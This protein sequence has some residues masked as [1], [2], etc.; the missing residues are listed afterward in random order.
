MSKPYYPPETSVID[1]LPDGIRLAQTLRGAAREIYR[2]QWSPEGERLAA[3]GADGVIYIWDTASGQVIQRLQQ[4]TDRVYS[5]TWSPDGKQLA[6]ISRDRSIYIWDAISGKALSTYKAEDKSAYCIAWSPDGRWL[7]WSSSGTGVQVLEVAKGEIAHVLEGQAQSIYGLAWSP[8]SQRIAAGGLDKTI[9]VWT[10]EAVQPIQTLEG[11]LDT[12]IS[13]GWSPDG[14]QLVSSAADKTIHIWDAERGQ[15]SV[16]IEGHTSYI[17]AAQFSA[18]GQLLASKSGDGTVR[19]WRCDT[20]DSVATLSEPRSPSGP[21]LAA[22]HFHPQNHKL[23]SLGENDTVVRLWELDLPKLMQS[24]SIM[25]TTHYTNAKVVLVGDTGVGKSGLSLVLIGQPFQE[26]E[27]THNR[28]VYV[29]E[30]QEFQTPDG[31]QE[32]RETLLWD[33]AGQPGYRLI[34]QLHLSD[35]AVALVVYDSRNEIDPFAGVFHWV[36]ALRQ[37]HQ[38]RSAQSLKIFL[39]AARIDRGQVG[40]SRKRIAQLI[41]SLE[42][43]G[44][45][46]TS[47]KEAWGIPELRSAVQSAIDWAHLPRV[48]STDFFTRIKSFIVDTK[49][50]GLVLESHDS[51]Y[52]SFLRANQ[53]TPGDELRKQFD[54]CI[55]L[56]ASRGL[57]ERF[58]FGDL[59]LLQPEILDAYASAMVNA[60]RTEPDGLGY[61]REEDALAGQ[62]AMP[63]SE[64]IAKAG[65]EKLLLIATVQKLLRH[66]IALRVEADDSSFLVFPSQL[67]RENPDLPAPNGK[68][69]KIRFEGAILN[70]YATL[71]VRLA[72]S[73]LF[74][75]RDMWKNA[76]AYSAIA[77]GAVC[78]LLLQEITES[79]AELILFYD[80]N[81]SEY[82]RYQFEHYIHSHLRRRALPDSISHSYFVI[83]SDCQYVVPDQVVEMRKERL[84]EWLDCPVCGNRISLVGPKDDTVPAKPAWIS[85][86]NRVA[87][88]QRDKATAVSTLKGKIAIGSYDVFLCHNNKD[89]ALVKR[90]GAKLREHGI[91]PWLDEWE[92]RPGIPWQKIL[93]HQ[94]QNVKAAAVFVGENGVGP[95]QD[96]EQA[97]F[98]RQFVQRECPVIPVVLPNCKQPPQLPYF[99]SGM[100]WV[101]FHKTTPDPLQQLIWGITGEKEPAGM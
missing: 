39:V 29:F 30:T 77:N 37:A 73:G 66:E 76:V 94:I 90:V 19:L 82:I 55:G 16:T 51:L 26:T 12:V 45:F 43:D 83:C 47:A 9:S 6:S 69:M 80:N 23:A 56:L 1:P 70:I 74:R 42:V 98:I 97:A 27:S 65:Q 14:K 15:K 84:F 31:A 85:K 53:F 22:L 78:G 38:M 35:V 88:Q 18:D 40:V 89:K 20:W 24:K 67:T 34:H 72:Q 91:L 64:R 4:H 81:T 54:T 68:A 71:A 101:D 63:P 58:T 95:W 21:Y 32:I 75:V 59:I 79:T 10:L 13:V 99:L 5:L 11:H 100:T 28:R 3:P 41:E 50:S 7:A 8:D 61:I 44:H 93:E 49:T 25:R 33:L 2:V 92:L 57:V 87:N 46:E 86:M 60:A 48:S 17:T 52:Y 62:F 36:R 96:M